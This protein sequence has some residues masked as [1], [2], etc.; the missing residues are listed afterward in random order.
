MVYEQITKLEAADISA[1]RKDIDPAII[2]MGDS[3]VVYRIKRDDE[4]RIAIVG[5]VRPFVMALEH[6]IWLAPMEE[7]R[8]LDLRGMKRLLKV[9]REY[10]PYLYATAV[11]GDERG[12]RLLRACDFQPQERYGNMRIYKW[13]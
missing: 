6:M 11:E 12:I 7:L 4:T 5:L 9:L 13:L 10:C 3:T 1:L 2:P 8:P